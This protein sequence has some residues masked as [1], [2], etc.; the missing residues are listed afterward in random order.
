MECYETCALIDAVCH[1]IVVLFAPKKVLLFSRKRDLDGATTSFKLCIIADTEDK[2]QIQKEIY[3]NV[4][5]DVPFDVVLY[6]PDE[7]EELSADD[8]TFAY[9]ITKTGCVIYG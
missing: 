2:T 1:R 7:W 6:T 9:R 8:A 5:C 3:L 4:D